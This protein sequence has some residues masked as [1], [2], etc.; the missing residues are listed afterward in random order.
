MRFAAV[1]PIPGTFLVERFMPTV[2]QS[3]DPSYEDYAERRFGGVQR[4][5]GLDA[6]A[7]LAASHVAVV[8]LGGVGSWTAE[9]LA[10]S[11]VGALTLIDLDHIAPSNLNRQ[12]HALESTLGQAKVMAMADRIRDI[13]PR[14]HVELVD[15]FVEPD[16]IEHTLSGRYS[17]VIDATDQVKAKIAM[18]LHARRGGYPLLVCGGAGGKT[19]P[20]A[21]RVGDL[22]QATHD[23]LLA[24]I[25]H[26]LRQRHGYPRGNTK[27]GTPSKRPPRMNVR[28][29][30]YDE[31]V[32]RPITA[33][34]CAVALHDVHVDTSTGSE[35]S[36]FLNAVH[37]DA[38][39]SLQAPQGLSCAGYGSLITVTATMGLVAAQEA[40]NILLA[41]AR[42][43][44]PRLNTNRATA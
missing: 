44:T 28:V 33:E 26:Q 41:P 37:A 39:H 8:G 17:V 29:L 16:N 2:T 38:A 7:R 40:L 13:H 23:P 34:S 3:P 11:G 15:D 36:P 10:R 27:A 5:Y 12:I 18:I 9:A 25:R 24:R 14:C 6:T 32:Q 30:W 31:P 1:Y 42:H 43:G 19:N 35:P 21:L 4:L 22:A 20:L